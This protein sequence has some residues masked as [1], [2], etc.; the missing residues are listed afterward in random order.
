[1]SC[2]VRVH[3]LETTPQIVI[4]GKAIVEQMGEF[5]VFLAKDSAT[6]AQDDSGQTKDPHLIAIQTRV[7][8]GQ[9]IDSVILIKS[10]L[11][12]GDRIVVDGIQSLHSGSWINASGPGGHKKADSTK[13]H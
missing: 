11:K 13:T 3:N 4:P 7:E 10:G 6:K 2:V 9:T 8:T 5:F 12:V 1:M